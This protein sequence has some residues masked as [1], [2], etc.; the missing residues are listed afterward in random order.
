VLVVDRQRRCNNKAL[1]GEAG[2]VVNSDLVLLVVLTPVIIAVIAA[3]ACAQTSLF[4]KPCSIHRWG[5]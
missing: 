1:T 4:V 5:G 3:R 2:I